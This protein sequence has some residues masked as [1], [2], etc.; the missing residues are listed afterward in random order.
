MSPSRFQ[1]I[2]IDLDET[3]WPCLPVII[4]AEQATLAWLASNAPRLTAAHDLQTLRRHRREL[5]QRRPEIAHDVTAV[6]RHS[7]LDLMVEFDYPAALV[8]QAMAVFAQ[9]RNRIQP[10]ADAADSLRSLRRQHRLISLTNGNADPEQTPLRGLFH[11]S[12]TAAD[13]GSA[14]PHPK[15]FEMAISLSGGNPERSLHIGDEPWLDVEAARQHGLTA[16]WI[17]RSGQAWPAELAPPAAQFSD[18]SAVPDW[19][20]GQRPTA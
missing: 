14:K 8:D 4:A 15:M 1:L 5:M 13:A 18:L 20:Y 17:N 19:V 12:L 7:L 16:I 2:T 3:V 6:R 10:Y 9:H 11:H